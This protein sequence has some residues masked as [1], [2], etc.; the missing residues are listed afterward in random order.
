MNAYATH[1]WRMKMSGSFANYDAWLE[2]PY[3]EMMEASD[4]FVDWAETEGFDL[5]DPDEARRAE[6]RYEDYLSDCAEAEAEAQYEAHLDRLEM[7]AEEREW[8]EGW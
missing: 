4:D 6:R 2:R 3:Q 7:E 5:N 8:D 1:L